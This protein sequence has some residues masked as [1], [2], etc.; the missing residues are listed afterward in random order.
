MK[1]I[2]CQD[3]YSIISI[4][5]QIQGKETHFIQKLLCINLLSAGVVHD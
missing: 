5:C 4:V 2:K 3:C 1:G